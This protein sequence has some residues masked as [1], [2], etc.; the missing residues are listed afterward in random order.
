M[1]FFFSNI[2]KKRDKLKA[3]GITHVLNCACG[4]SFNMI[5]TDQK[6]FEKSGILFHGIAASDVRNFKLTPY[7]E[8]AADFIEEALSSGGK[9]KQNHLFFEFIRS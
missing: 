1:V 9:L 6:F 7:F 3:I 4:S 5:N 8:A 2:A